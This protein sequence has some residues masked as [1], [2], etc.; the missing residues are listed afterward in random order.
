MTSRRYVKHMCV[1][2]PPGLRRAAL[3][4][5]VSTIASLHPGSRP[6]PPPGR[7]QTTRSIVSFCSLTHTSNGD[8]FRARLTHS[9][10]ILHLRETE[11]GAEQAPSLGTRPESAREVHASMQSVSWAESSSI[12]DSRRRVAVSCF[13]GDA[14]LVVCLDAVSAP[15]CSRVSSAS[16][17]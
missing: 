13:R 6:A 16:S 15:M 12:S 8:P 3:Q 7:L 17:T 4:R 14:S 10:C 5:S 9:P 11:D 2:S 1:G